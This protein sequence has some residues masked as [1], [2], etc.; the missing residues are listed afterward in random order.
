MK[1]LLSIVTVVAFAVVASQATA[2][3]SSTNTADPQRPTAKE[4]MDAQ[5]ELQKN[6]PSK[7]VDKSAPKYR[8]SSEAAMQSQMD[9]QKNKPSKKVD[10][11]AAAAGPRPNA[12]KMTQ[13]ER[14]AYRKDVVKDAKP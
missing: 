12:S 9:L 13:D 10:K 6:K 5:M 2:Q 8:P 1:T 7:K 4:S 3:S 14:D 11:T